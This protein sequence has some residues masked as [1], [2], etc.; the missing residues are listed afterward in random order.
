V[1]LVDR[2]A[3]ATNAAS[4]FD[5]SDF[6]ALGGDTDSRNEIDPMGAKAGED[7]PIFHGRDRA[8]S[9]EVFNFSGE[10][11]L[12]PVQVASSSPPPNTTL[13]QFVNEAPPKTRPRG[14]SIIFDPSSFQDGGIHEKNALD[15]ARQKEMAELAP[16]N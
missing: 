15:K 13:S 16:L 8:F 7:L 12:L 5:F 1:Q 4:T 2:G 10:D 9:F 3:P 14:D 6:G 11:D